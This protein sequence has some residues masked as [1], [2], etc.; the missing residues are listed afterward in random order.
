[1]SPVFTRAS[2]NQWFIAGKTAV[3]KSE[4]SLKISLKITS[5]NY[6]VMINRKEKEITVLG[7]IWKKVKRK[8]IIF[9]WKC[10]SAQGV[11]DKTPWVAVEKG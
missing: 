7:S 5:A 1:M 2:S 8:V 11:V 4:S 9:V 10:S 3:K 6:I